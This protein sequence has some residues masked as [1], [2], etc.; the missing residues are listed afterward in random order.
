MS[1][2]RI[3][4]SSILGLPTQPCERVSR[5]SAQR[6]PRYVF[7]KITTCSREGLVLFLF[8]SDLGRG[9]FKGAETL[10]PRMSLRETWR[11]NIT[12]LSN[13]DGD[14]RSSNLTAEITAEGRRMMIPSHIVTKSIFQIPR[15]GRHKSNG[16]RRKKIAAKQYGKT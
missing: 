11:E 15:L 6:E 12:P 1:K 2:Q 9:I 3:A 10:P 13:R 7:R 4:V 8:C 14:R 16:R 5:L